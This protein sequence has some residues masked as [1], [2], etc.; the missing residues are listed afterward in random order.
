MVI[1]L[2]G[3][4]FIANV[5][6]SRK[7]GERADNNPWDSGTLEWA[8]ASPPAHYNFAELPVATGRYPLWTS[9]KERITVT[10]LR[11]DRREVLVTTLMDAEPHHRYV[12]PDSSIWPFVTAILVTIGLVGSVFQFAWYYAGAVLATIGLVGWFWPRTPQGI[13]P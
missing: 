5:L 13:E 8:A 6:T 3:I 7:H 12:L 11:S 9:L 1:L 4:L 10:G 2:G